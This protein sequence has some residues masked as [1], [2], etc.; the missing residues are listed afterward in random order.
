MAARDPFGLVND[1]AGG[2]LF[3]ACA[4]PLVFRVEELST[5]SLAA[6]VTTSGVDGA[7]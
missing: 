1:V 3:A 4:E 5:A 6:S 2:F 7:R